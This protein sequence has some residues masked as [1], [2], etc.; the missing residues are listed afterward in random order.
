MK[1]IP[2]GNEYV[3]LDK[4]NQETA[5]LETLS[6]L[7][8]RYRGMLE[9]VG[10][11]KKELL[12]PY[13]VCNDIKKTI[14][15][16]VWNRMGEWIPQ[17]SQ[18]DTEVTISGT[19]LV[20]TDDRGFLYV[21]RCKNNTQDDMNIE[22]GVE[23]CISSL[24]HIM[25]ES[26]TMSVKKE[27]KRSNWNHSILFSFVSETDV[28]SLAPIFAMEDE[29]DVKVS[30]SLNCEN[31]IEY[32][33]TKNQKLKAGET[34]EF[35]SI[36]GIGYEEVSAATAAKDILRYGYKRELQKTTKKLNRLSQCR[37]E[38]SG[39]AN[40]PEKIKKISDLNAFFCYFYA[41]GRT[42]DT[43]EAVMITSRSTRYYVSAAFWDR[44][45]LLWAFPCILQMDVEY[46]RELL[47]YAYTRQK[48]N[49]GIH[50][51]Y[52][53][54]MLLEPGFE[55]DE[56]CA[57]LYALTEY[58]KVSGDRTIIQEKDI[59]NG[60]QFALKRLK[61]YK[62]KDVEL[63]ETFLLPSDDETEY[64]YVTY[65]NA[66]LSVT[67]QRLALLLQEE[68][69]TKLSSEL[70]EMVLRIK[71]AILD[72]CIV[73]YNGKRVYAWAVDLN[74]NYQIYDEPPGSLQLLLYYGFTNENDEVY[75]NTMSIIRGEDY[76]YS[77]HGH[78]ID[79][80]GCAHAK[81]PW[82]LS[83]ANSLLCGD[84]TH[85]LEL[86]TK[87]NMDYGIACESVY[88]DDGEC[89]TGEAFATCAGFLA[90]AINQI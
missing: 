4:I 15:G 51:R 75:R 79:E 6:I 53:D 84:R 86:L 9:I 64:T 38:Q 72:H 60:I 68:K 40:L 8:M 17:F 7:H 67:L 44:D 21:V 48:Y 45:A 57:P 62:H 12:R 66:L 24:N 18:L 14:T 78:M 85:A 87:M 69:E 65:D 80:I 76:E 49:M 58:V 20:P 70:K 34:V 55:L 32:N 37:Q 54:G 22:I 61:Q 35:I 19:V 52:I 30:S 41:T 89:A 77:F 27:I 28:I 25:N 33:F 82:I 50:S 90:Y 71:Q 23:G 11:S 81:H 47:L 31:D 39:G 36:W 42:L 2:T 88:E 56:L 74:G 16:P 1:Y 59:L 26:R 3:S 43:Q 5:A 29:G 13:I 10:N 83:L 63:Y 73:E 46:A